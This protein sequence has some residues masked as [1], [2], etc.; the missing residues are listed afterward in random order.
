MRAIVYYDITRIL[1]KASSPTPTGIDRVDIRYAK[2]YLDH[3]EYD[4]V[5][6]YT[7]KSVFKAADEE[8]AKALIEL[9]YAKWIEGE[10]LCKDDAGWLAA[11]AKKQL[12]IQ[13]AEKRRSSTQSTNE[14]A[15]KSID[16][17]L[18][19]IFAKNRGQQCCYVN[20]SHYGVG[21][22]SCQRAYYVF[23]TVGN[24]GIIFYLHDLIPLDFPEY[25]NEGDD[26]NH[27]VRVTAMANYA[28]VVIVNSE[29]TKNR[30]I[31]YCKSHFLR[32]PEVRIALIGI[33]DKFADDESV[34]SDDD[35]L[36]KGDYFITVSTVEPRKNHLLLLQVWREIAEER[37]DPPRLVIVG[38]RGWNNSGTF[39]FLDRNQSIR[40]H[41]SELSG[42]S[43]HQLIS[44]MKGAKAMLFP[45]FV[46]GWG[47]PVVEAMAL[48]LPIVCSDIPAFVESGQNI[49]IYKS[50]IDGLGW[51]KEILRLND[52][53]DYLEKCRSRIANYIYPQWDEHFS[54][55]DNAFMFAVAG[56]GRS[57]PPPNFSA[58]KRCLEVPA[59]NRKHEKLSN[60]INNVGSDGDAGESRGRVRSPLVAL[61]DKLIRKHMSEK[62]YR[63]YCKNRRVFFY[64]SSSSIARWYYRMTT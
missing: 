20:T 4:V 61:E 24:T 41:V 5:Y 27:A 12:E 14:K 46:E 34:M 47:M 9:V 43:D 22:D 56:G 40:S 37:K 1:S 17:Q 36:I 30:F 19:D 60:N 2:N 25:V 18:F 26:K 16:G 7:S 59:K 52:D 63:K 53:S 10:F 62:K 28:D 35:C 8:F 48:G 32:Q 11:E 23:K 50:P 29:Y 58:F 55:A 51:K 57:V 33:E 64:D 49:P 54:V 21:N 13:Y 39:T 45:S 3:D 42:L 44:L 31:N 38:K 6:V 15:L